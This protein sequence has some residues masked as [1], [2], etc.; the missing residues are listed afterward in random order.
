M[1]QLSVSQ[2]AKQCGLSRSTLL[3]YE[4]IGLLHPSRRSL[5]GYRVYLEKDLARLE[6]I[7]L[8]RQ[9][10]LSLD[11]IGKILS[12]P[13]HPEADVLE[14][15][16]AELGREIL[17]LRT[18]QHLVAALIKEQGR[19]PNEMPVDKQS[20]VAM[21]EK[22]GMDEQAMWRW[23]REFEARSPQAHYEFLM[24]LGIDEQEAERIRQWAIADNFSG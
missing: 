19:I 22:A 14:N 6:R 15:R 13:R 10:G 24:S 16:L 23:H 12:G 5:A 20:W 18:Q 8:Y 2:M 1:K 4:H 17:Q 3:Y 9:A 21:L 11:D 7:C